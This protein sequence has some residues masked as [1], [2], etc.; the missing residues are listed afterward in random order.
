MLLEVTAKGKPLTVGWTI[1]RAD[2]GRA[3][4]TTLGHFHRNF[5]LLPFR[6]MLINGIIWSAGMEVPA[7]GAPCKIDKDDPLFPKS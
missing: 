4:G 3:F 6:K 7:K 2:S 1:E 5:G